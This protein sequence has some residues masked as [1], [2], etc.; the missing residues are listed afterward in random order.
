[1]VRP[2]AKSTDT[3]SWLT[4][5]AV[6][7]TSRASTM[8]ELIPTLQQLFPVLFDQIADPVNLIPAEA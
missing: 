8:K 1:M 3:V 2:S 7:R 5:T 4:L 6:A